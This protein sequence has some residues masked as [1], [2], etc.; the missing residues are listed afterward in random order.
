MTTKTYFNTFFLCQLQYKFSCILYVELL[1][2][3]IIKYS[4]K[5]FSLHVTIFEITKLFK[6]NITT[7][8][9]HPYVFLNN[10][11]NSEK[12]HVTDRMLLFGK[13]QNHCIVFDKSYKEN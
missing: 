11:S 8:L 2:H 13:E 4:S 9:F 6:V 5:Y 7:F 1:L 3:F 12:V 10:I